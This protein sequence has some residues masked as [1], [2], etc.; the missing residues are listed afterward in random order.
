M[1]TGPKRK[2]SELI[3]SPIYS[4]NVCTLHV[5]SHDRRALS[6]FP[7]VLAIIAFRRTSPSASS[8]EAAAS[9]VE[10]SSPRKRNAPKEGFSSARNHLLSIY[11]RCSKNAISSSGFTPRCALA[12]REILR[13]RSHLRPPD[14]LF[15]RKPVYLIHS[16][17]YVR[18]DGAELL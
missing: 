8:G 13:F 1:P 7:C 17:A 2:T 4:G 14:T 10:I 3:L 5:E 9:N 11:W 6:Y 18:D 15:H 16:L 12:W